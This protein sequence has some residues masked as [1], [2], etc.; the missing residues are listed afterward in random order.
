DS[1]SRENGLDW[2]KYAH[3][4]VGAKRLDNVNR[5]IIYTLKN[6]IAGDFVETGIWRGGCCILARAVYKAYN[7]KDRIV[8]G[9]DSFCGLPP[10]NSILYPQDTYEF[11]QHND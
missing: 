4:M 10:C 3:T 2:P 7:V 5:S 6:D 8:W 9:A 11:A 1:N